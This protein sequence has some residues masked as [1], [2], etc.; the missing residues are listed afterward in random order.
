MEAQ[1]DDLFPLEEDIKLGLKEGDKA[2][3]FYFP[4]NF[5]KLDE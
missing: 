1:D 2:K 5:N 4:K 3:S